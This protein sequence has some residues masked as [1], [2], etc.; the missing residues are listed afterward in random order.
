MSTPSASP[1]AART[2]IWKYWKYFSP[3][4][5]KSRAGSVKTTPEAMDSP[6]EPNGLDGCCSRGWC[7]SPIFLK[8]AMDRTAMGM[9]AETVRPARRAR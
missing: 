2:M 5:R 9:D 6:A 3:P 1:T 8:T 4:E 7:S